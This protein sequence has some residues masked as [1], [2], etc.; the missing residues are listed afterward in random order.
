MPDL[1]LPQAIY[2]GGAVAAF[3]LLAVVLAAVQFWSN[4]PKT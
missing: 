1:D 4:R 2:L 3:G